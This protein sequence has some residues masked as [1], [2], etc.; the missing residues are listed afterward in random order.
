[1]IALSVLISSQI[2]QARAQESAIAIGPAVGTTGVGLQAWVRLIPNTLNLS[3]GPSGMAFN[4]NLGV[5]DYAGGSNYHL[6]VRLL[7]L[8][9]ILNYY[10]F[11][12]WFDLQGGIFINGNKIDLTSNNINGNTNDQVTGNSHFNVIAPYVGV[13]FGQPF[14]GSRITF[15]GNLG[16]EYAGGPDVKLVPGP[17][18]T[19]AEAARVEANQSQIDNKIRWAEVFP[20]FSLGLAYRF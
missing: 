17:G 15:T 9:I 5:G 12:N 20:V 18:M 19:P 6:K 14:A 10:L 4:L 2:P 13:G 3:A 7:G 8:P 1:M 16:V 11:H